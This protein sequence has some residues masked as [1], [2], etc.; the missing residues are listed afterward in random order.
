MEVSAEFEAAVATFAA[1]DVR[2]KRPVIIEFIYISRQ[3][4]YDTRDPLHSFFRPP[5]AR[6]IIVMCAVCFVV[7]SC[8]KLTHE[9]RLFVY[10]VL[11]VALYDVHT[12]I[13]K[14]TY[15][16]WCLI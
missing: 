15:S 8:F 12:M 10:L 13:Q 7:G 11:F 3:W 2:Y 5:P 16:V 1:V 6:R 14:Y 9:G 4:M